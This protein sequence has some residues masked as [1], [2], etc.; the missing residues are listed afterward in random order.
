MGLA[1]LLDA[2]F[3]E[4]ARDLVVI[5]AQVP[6]VLQRTVRI[7]EAVM[8]SGARYGQGYLLARPAYPPPEV[9]WP[10]SRA[11]AS[12]TQSIRKKPPTR[13]PR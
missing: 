12:K 8:D 13:R 6:E 1:E 11:P 5:D 7:V 3:L 4:L 2:V 10:S 9:N